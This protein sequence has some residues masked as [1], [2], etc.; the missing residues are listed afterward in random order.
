VATAKLVKKAGDALGTNRRNAI[1][2]V[3]TAGL[4]RTQSVL[5]Q[6]AADLRKRIDARV[7]ANPD[8]TF[9]LM[10]MRAALVQIKLVTRD[11]TRGVKETVLDAGS[12]IADQATGHTIEYLARAEKAFSGVGSTPLAL[13]EAM[14][15]E[16]ATYGV[17]ASILRRLASSGEPMEGADEEAHPA[18]IGVMQR[19]GIETV[20]HFENILQRGLLA[21]KSWQQMREDIT[22]KSP[23][24]QQAPAYWAARI[25]RTEV[26]GAYGRASWESIRAAD[27]E[28]EDMVK[29]ISAA[30][31]ERT[32]ADS[33]ATHGQI[34]R[35]EEAF[36]TWYGFMQHPPDRPNDRGIVV[37]HRISWPIPPYLEWKDADQIAARW[38]M[39]GR[40]GPPPERP[41]M[42]T[43]S[44]ELF[45]H[46]QE[47]QIE[48]G[49]GG[50]EAESED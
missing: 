35:P 31:D 49:E 29:I 48:D 8:D 5:E 15:L 19:Y 17:R 3:Q 11:V 38:R 45:G 28:L 36:E 30:F 41:E 16:T 32:G 18:K 7:R 26:M 20:G 40:K 25:V 22:E 13:R 21:K 47:K 44:L 9:T 1:E 27:D 33:Y 12:E 50:E 39:E 24:L 14:M 2:F 43:V 34:R 42:T 37:P 4:K 46:P 23:F 6:A 10:Q